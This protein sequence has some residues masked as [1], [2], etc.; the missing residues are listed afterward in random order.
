MTRQRAQGIW[1]VL[2]LGIVFLN[3]HCGQQ[4][5][6]ETLLTNATGG[7]QSGASAPATTPDGDQGQDDNRED[8]ASPA[9]S[10]E[11]AGDGGS[12][13]PVEAASPSS[14]NGLGRLKS[15]SF[16]LQETTSM[17][18]FDTP[19]V[20]IDPNDPLDGSMRYKVIDNWRPVDP[21][22]PTSV[23]LSVELGDPNETATTSTIHFYVRAAQAN[24]PNF[25]SVEPLM[26]LDGSQASSLIVT[27]LRFEDPNTQA[28]IWVTA[29]MASTDEAA[30]VYMM[31]YDRLVDDSSY[32]YQLPGVVPFPNDTR[33]VPHTLFSDVN[34]IQYAF[35]TWKP[36]PTV[37]EVSMVWYN[38]LQPAADPNGDFPVYF[39][40]LG[41][42][43]YR[44]G[45]VFE[46]G[47]ATI[48]TTEVPFPP[49]PED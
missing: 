3:L 2:G 42:T 20:I 21:L 38:V 48:V 4:L 46:I 26:V 16:H 24:D 10:S 12:D 39:N 17:Y 1:L 43:G 8:G 41:T 44:A 31:N 6:D 27:D 5:P 13:D 9:A 49:E 15:F 11:G 36:T 23:Y 25:K 47:V 14:Q 40:R 30:A 19:P 34:E 37:P 35:W 7:E 18:S 29:Y 32:F 22:W 28:P 33:Q 45:A